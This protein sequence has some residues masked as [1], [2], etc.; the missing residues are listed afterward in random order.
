MN[1]YC[2]KISKDYSYKILNSTKEIDKNDWELINHKNNI[3][4]TL[5]YLEAIEKSL[6][7]TITFTY[8]TF[9][10]LDSKCIAIAVLQTLKFKDKG[11]KDNSIVCDIRTSLKN[12]F[13][14]S[15]DFEVIT[16][17]SA[18]S[19]GENG[20]E[21]SPSISA[22][23]AFK[24]LSETLIEIQKIKEVNAPII[25]IKEFWKEQFNAREELTKKRFKEFE[26]DVNMVLPISEDW[27][28]F[29][30]Y[31]FSL[32]TK[33]RT[34]AKSALKK[35]L[36]LE[37]KDLKIEDIKLLKEKIN[38]LYKNV[39]EKSPVYFGELTSNTF[40][41]LKQKLGSD[42]IMT[43]Y[44]LHQD[45]I[46]FSTAFVN[47]GILEANY[48]G[49]EYS[50]NQEYAIYQTMLYNY[51]Q[52][53]IEHKCRELRFGRTAEEIKSSVGAEPEPMILYIRHK[54]GI[55]N[56]ILHN[57]FTNLKPSTFEKRPPFKA[58]FYKK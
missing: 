5:E 58:D 9:Y 17:G 52:K 11:L 7:E 36:A 27:I 49:I 2:K 4:L 16:C 29:D 43:G 57:V 46:G 25:L 51:I 10:N 38:L 39:L 37:I 40:F 19:S 30:D 34:K 13:I 41:E 45:L 6:K 42:F 26:I 8:V 33:F 20:F 23:I 31:L 22:K 24:I 28:T 14:S 53:S 47:N 54:N 56:S 21:Y 32:T 1:F 35:S 55:V 48:V 44:Y 15:F 3:F 12:K 50:L 18:F